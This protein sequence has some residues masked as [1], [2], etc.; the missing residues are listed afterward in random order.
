MWLDWCLHELEVPAA[1]LTYPK[2]G[3]LDRE[4]VRPAATKSARAELLKALGA[5]DS[6]LA[7]RTFLGSRRLSVA[8]VAVACVLYPVFSQGV[9]AA[10]GVRRVAPGLTPRL[11]VVGPN[12]RQGLPEV[13]RWFLTC[14]S[15]V[16]APALPGHRRHCH[17]RC[18]RPACLCRGAG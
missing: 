2:L 3:L 15:Q 7:T 1:V 18:P 5:L 16:R 13:C 6:W 8:D 17:Q 9:R 14:C 11:Q 12:E 10:C 4:A